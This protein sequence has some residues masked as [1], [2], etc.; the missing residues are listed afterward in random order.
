MFKKIVLIF[1]CV[2]SLILPG[3]SEAKQI[4]KAS[5]AEIVTA[6]ENDGKTYYSFYFLSSSETPV[7]TTVC[8]DSFESACE[9][10]RSES[11]SNLMLTKLEL[12]VTEES[13]A[14]KTLKK[15]IGFISRNSY[16]SPLMYVTLCDGKL[17][18]ML[19]EDKEL[20]ESVQKLIILNT[21]K[22]RSVSVTPL[23]IFNSFSDN[24]NKE[25]ALSYINSKTE[26][27]S[28][29]IKINPQK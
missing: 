14:S 1:L 7:Y 22:D 21:K 26:L 11:I 3:C 29:I 18:E 24:N 28:E 5:I 13:L 19:N 2:L 6:F 17:I 12:F 15:D 27:K 8:A 10:A 20:N 9:K 4:D 16:F 25:L 23:S